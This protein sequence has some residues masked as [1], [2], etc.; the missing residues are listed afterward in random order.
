MIS[1]AAQADSAVLVV[2]A[3]TG[4]FESG[5]DLG[6]QTREHVILVRSLGVHELIV[7]VNK[8]DNVDWSQERF[9]DIESKL[10]I[11]LKQTGFRSEDFEFI[12]VSGLDGA[13]LIV[14]SPHLSSWYNGPTLVERINMFKL[15]SRS[16]DKPLRL[17]VMDVFR[18][19]VGSSDTC[20]AGRVLQGA[21]QVG[22]GEV[23]MVQPAG[24]FA[25][26]K[27]E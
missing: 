9:K 8:L 19:T 15:P 25:S 12:P 20:V 5:F 1:G 24:E 10:S 13:N 14:K 6:G 2:D 17:A 18:S 4:E 16:V 23:V 26:V 27:C 7:A 11:F 21:L 3:T 22:G